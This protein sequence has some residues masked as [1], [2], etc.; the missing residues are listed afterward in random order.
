V[1]GGVLLP[2]VPADVSLGA[3]HIGVRY[4]MCVIG[5][6]NDTEGA[7]G[8]RTEALGNSPLPRCHFVGHGI[9]RDGT[10]VSVVPGRQLNAWS[11]PW[12]SAC[13]MCGMP[14]ETCY[15]WCACVLEVLTAV[16]CVVQIC[17]KSL[18]FP[19]AHCS[20]YELV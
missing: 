15:S 13:T 17:S 16:R 7:G 8:G 9:A 10:E 19:T 4:V 11:E 18:R 6:W 20:D 1:A 5:H 2:E 3:G 12:H 14:A